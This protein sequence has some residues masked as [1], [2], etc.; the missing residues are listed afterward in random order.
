MADTTETTEAPGPKKF[1]SR[2][3]ENIQFQIDDDTL[4]A[5]PVIPAED[6]A[7]LARLQNKLVPEEGQT[8]TGLGP[9]ETIRILLEMIELVLLPASIELVAD[10]IRS[11]TNPLDVE[12]I[13]DAVGWLLMEHYSG[14]GDKDAARPTSP[15]SA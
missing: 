4:Y 8:T 13:A 2:R 12:T 10:R 6:F 15:A 11:K 5:V 14:K 9:D 7:V 3:R 1:T